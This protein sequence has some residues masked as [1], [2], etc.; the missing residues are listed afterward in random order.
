MKKVILFALVSIFLMSCGG[1]GQN[2]DDYITF[3][4]AFNHVSKS[5]SYWLFAL[6]LTAA[7]VGYW[8]YAGI[9]NKKGAD[10]KG[11]AVIG[12]AITAACLFAWFFRPCEVAANTTVEQML[13]GV[14]IGY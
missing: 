12:F 9:A 13:R 2:P 4:Q 7:T 1:S 3:G 8:I 11:L 5:T 14:Y 6:I 10:G